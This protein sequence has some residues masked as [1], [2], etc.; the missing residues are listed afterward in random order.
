MMKMKAF[1]TLSHL[2]FMF[3]KENMGLKTF[4]FK[5][6]IAL[7]ISK[8]CLKE[9]H[10]LTIIYI[11]IYIYIYVYVCVCARIYRGREREILFIKDINNCN[12]F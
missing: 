12:T 8:T 2:I 6:S 7:F 1:F 9:Y 3:I 4:L 5:H 10:Y 11:H